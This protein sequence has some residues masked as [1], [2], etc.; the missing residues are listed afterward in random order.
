MK[1]IEN[2]PNP[3]LSQHA[4][5]LEE[6][7]AART[8][9]YEEAAS[10]ILSENDSPDISFRYSVNPYRG[11]HHACAYCY[12]RPTHEYLG[13]GA[14]SDFE[15]RI[16][17]KVN[18]PELLERKVSR[19]KWER[20]WIAFSGVTDCYQPLEA[21]Y[22]ITR[23]CMEVCL[24]HRISVGVVTKSFLVSRDAD[25]LAELH[26]AAGARVFLSIPFADDAIARQIEPG[27]PPPSRRFE[28]LQRLRDA[29]VPVGVMVAPIIP[30]LSDREIPAVLKR[31]AECGA[32]RAAHT[33][34]RLAGSVRP[35]FLE[36]LRRAN[37]LVADRVIARIKD[38]RGGK[39]N[40]SRFGARMRGDGEYWD[41][42]RQLFDRM[43]SK[44]GI[45]KRKHAT[46]S[47][48]EMR[49]EI[50]AGRSGS[51]SKGAIQLPLFE[52]PSA[53]TAAPMLP[54]PEQRA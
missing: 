46:S 15:T 27:A 7:P 2:P 14:G 34:L 31:A 51:V 50:D 18:A 36:R 9:V 11:C 22:Q 30:G 4:E 10:S 33:P 12:A 44:Y 8:I 23:R 48:S 39:L 49:N 37:P 3:F 6:P 47:K 29:R 42:I 20:D 17:V 19:P 45:N 26:R 21:V 52:Q 32:T 40:E 35:V 13:F 24:K 43:C 54:F 28:A 41:S 1:R 16:V 5:Y 38:M 53:P 25:L